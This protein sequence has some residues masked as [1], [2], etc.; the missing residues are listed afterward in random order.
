M[1]PTLKKDIL[2]SIVVFLVALPLSLGIAFASGAPIVAGIVA[3]A[4]GGIVAGL[5]GGAPL[6]VSGPAA[7]LTVIVYGVVQQHGWQVTCLVTAIA[8]LIQLLLGFSKIARAALLISPAVVHG[9]LAGIGITIAVAQAQVVLGSSPQ[10]GVIKNLLKLP[11]HLGALNPAALA[12]GLLSIGILVL[13]AKLPAKVQSVPAPLV[14][15]VV[16]T[17]VS[18]AIPVTVKR[19][20]LPAN[21]LGAIKLPVLPE[22][23]MWTAVLTSA[24]I[25]AMVASV[26]SLLCAVA[27]DRMHNGKRADLDR[28]LIGQGAANTI[29]GLLGGLPVT[30]VIVRS[31]ANVNAGA[32]TRLSAILHGVWILVFALLLGS[33]LNTIPLAAL[34]GLL[35]HVGVKLVNKHHINGLRL[36]HELPVYFVTLAGVVFTDLI[37]GVAMGL[38]LSLF[39]VLRRMATTEIKIQ[40]EIES[41]DINVNGTLTFMA[42]PRL[43]Q[44]LN[45]IERGKKVNLE[46]RTDFMDHAAFEA[47]HTWESTYIAGGGEVE[48]NESYE[49]WYAKASRKEPQIH[50]SLI[51]QPD[52]PLVMEPNK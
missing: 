50:K 24:F 28:E 30:G 14:A 6:Q 23:N 1:N 26:E 45:S 2:A 49:P 43:V 25:V 37:K 47:V 40:N 35:V 15:V 36:H 4:M 10:S 38:G 29:S 34:A 31:S 7:G 19:I 13:W 32:E 46:I 11:E 44:K 48:I 22:T 39:M 3:A 5:L 8:G 52:R 51:V 42:V 21:L 18:L 9:M 12:L 20:E 41:I 33:L 17:L 16:P 27:T